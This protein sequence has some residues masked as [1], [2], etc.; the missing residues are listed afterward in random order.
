MGATE[1]KTESIKDVCDLE[2]TTNVCQISNCINSV[3]GIASNSASPTDIWIIS[4]N[5]KVT[6]I[7]KKIKKAILKIFADPD[8]LSYISTDRSKIN[9]IEG[10]NYELHIY[11]DII[12]NILDYN[13]CPNF[14]KYLAS[15]ENC[16][17]NDL[18]NMLID[19]LENDDR[20]LTSGECMNSLNRNITFLYENKRNR[21]PIQLIE[22][23]RFNKPNNNLTY[24]MI[25]NETSNGIKLSDWINKY[26]LNRDF[27]TELWNIML[28]IAVACY[29]MALSKMV[30]NDLHSGNI[31]IETYDTEKII[32]YYINNSPIV[33]KTKFKALIYDF[34]R[35]YCVRLGNNPILI[36]QYCKIASQ[37]NE[38]I[39]NKDIVKILCYIVTDIK[40]KTIKLKLLK[41]LTIDN[42]NLNELYQTYNE[43]RGG[44]C[45]LQEIK[46]GQ[47]MSKPISFYR[48][49]NNNE[50]VINNIKNYLINYLPDNNKNLTY[51][52]NKSFFDP[53]GNI[54]KEAIKKFY[55]DIEKSKILDKSKDESKTI[56][57]RDIIRS[58]EKRLERERLKIE[59]ERKLLEIKIF[60]EKREEQKRKEEEERIRKLKEIAVK[61]EKERLILEQKRKE[62]ELKV[63]RDRE[64]LD[65]EREKQRQEKQARELK[66]RLEREIEK[67][68]QE[69]QARELR[70][71]LEREARKA[72]ERK[73]IEERENNKMDI[74]SP[75]LSN[76]KMD[77]DSPY[78][79]NNK[80][81]IDSPYSL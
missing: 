71:R 12:S 7:N 67:Q 19:H 42:N 54:R 53:D 69:K 77:I 17:Y 49:L 29:S 28:Q 37:C 4:F 23:T 18:L 45:F 81:D 21:P 1:S 5:D 59:Q 2:K 36:P 58:E 39:E 52:C 75:Y 22:Y 25:M 26:S 33:I 10:L 13:I 55:D 62:E 41:L 3:K 61:K 15:G 72:R 73:L 38:F 80:M 57:K 20:K 79:S 43:T 60:K 16:T 32:T 34:D 30:H 9:D 8:S 51:F 56:S 6:Y 47:I 68:R 78:L 70:E 66:E 35:G 31:F 63:K 24:N 74:E 50:Q 27:E 65:R 76:N 64:R 44:F 40:D 46:F 14:V 48:K 11:K